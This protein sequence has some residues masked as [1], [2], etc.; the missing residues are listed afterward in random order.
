MIV[1]LFRIDDR[2]I[3]GQVILGWARPLKSDRI[4]L[5]DDD[6][7]EN[8][9]EKELYC[10]CV[11][12]NMEAMVQNT[13]ETARLLASDQKNNRKTIVIVKDPESVM[14]LVN[15]GYTPAEVNIGGIHFAD[16]R[17]KILPYLYLNKEEIEQVKWLL[18]KGIKMFCQD[19]PSAK[20]YD[21]VNVIDR[22]T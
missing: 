13:T 2:L 10:S 1:Q 21:V 12:A 5:C 9:W 6:I 4:L 17:K 8:E 3:H 19:I 14:N 18:G 15:K 11:P 7:S 20:K 16:A 22:K